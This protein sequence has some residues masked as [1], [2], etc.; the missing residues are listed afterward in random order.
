MARSAS[1]R[2]ST[3]QCAHLLPEFQ[4]RTAR[5]RAEANRRN[6]GSRIK[7]LPFDLDAPYA[8]QGL[9][10][11]AYDLIV[12]INAVHVARDLERT[13]RQLYEPLAPGGLPLAVEATRVDRWQSPCLGKELVSLQRCG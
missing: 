9:E 4:R 6:L 7:L 11:G 1:V 3:S 10:G 12:A 13:L 2:P 8:D 5:A